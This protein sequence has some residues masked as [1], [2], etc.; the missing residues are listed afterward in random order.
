MAEEIDFDR[1]MK[2][3]IPLSYCD[4]T[5]RYKCGKETKDVKRY[6]IMDK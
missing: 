3:R 4:G 5:T 1:C 2:C 6:C